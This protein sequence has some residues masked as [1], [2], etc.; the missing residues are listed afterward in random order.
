LTGPG[1]AERP[2]PGPFEKQLPLPH[3][4][5]GR[6]ASPGGGRARLR[7][8]RPCTHGCRVTGAVPESACQSAH[9][10][11]HRDGVFLKK[12]PVRRAS[13]D[14]CCGLASP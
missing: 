2:K 6:P 12:A 7:R 5:P 8:V 11:R 3:G 9:R 4:R 1:E 13:W 14:G 10:S